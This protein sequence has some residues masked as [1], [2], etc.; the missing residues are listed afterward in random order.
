[1]PKLLFDLL[2]YPVE[3]EMSVL[4]GKYIIGYRHFLNEFC[5]LCIAEN[6]RVYLL[7]LFLKEWVIIEP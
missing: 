2:K 3:K 5:Y 4:Y 7:F 1:M 6:I